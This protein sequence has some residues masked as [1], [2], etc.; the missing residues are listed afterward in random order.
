MVRS[1]KLD[2][3]E[4]GYLS[5]INQTDLG[6]TERQNHKNLSPGWEVRDTKEK[7]ERIFFFLRW[8]LTMCPSDFLLLCYNTGQNQLG[9]EGIYL[10]CTSRS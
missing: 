7:K 2:P 6:I 4:E 10:T 1:P 9:G 3:G 5:G 8:Y